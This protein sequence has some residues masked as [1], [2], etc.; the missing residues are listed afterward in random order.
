MNNILKPA[1]QA[2]ADYKAGK[3]ENK[4]SVFSPEHEEYKQSYTDLTLA[5]PLEQTA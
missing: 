5:E 1:A 2:A 4:N 3:Y